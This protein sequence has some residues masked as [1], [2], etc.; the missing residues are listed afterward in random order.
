MLS[1]GK[2][3]AEQAGYYER[4]VA[5]GRDDY[6]SGK[7]EAP[8]AWAGR[9][10]AILGLQGVVDA[11][12]FNAM[13]AGL[14]PSDPDLERPL[15][16]ARGTPKVV[17]FDLTFSAPKSVSVEFATQDPQTSAQLIGAH[18][19][20]VA[21]ALE[22]VEDAAVRVRRGH[23]GAEVLAGDGVAAAAYR[24]RMSRSLDPQ[25]HTHVVC[26]NVTR[27]PD[28]RWTALD[29]RPIY[30]HARTAGF[31]YQAH[32]RAEVRDRLGWEW[33]PVVNGA[34]ELQHVKPELLTEFSR[35][36]HEI[37]A[38]ADVAI[39]RYETQHG[40]LSDDARAAMRTELLTAHG[41]STSR[42]P[43]ESASTSATRPRGATRCPHAPAS[44][45]MTGPPG[46]RALSAARSGYG[47]A[48]RRLRTS[49]S[50][51]SSAIGSRALRG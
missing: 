9:G 1:I 48:R 43:P 37:T 28:G 30:Q 46:K 42:W 19:S 6:Y 49:A 34:A 8:G 47:T 7:G 5:R 51:A 3:G 41:H 32:L 38:A 45:A 18:E 14:D 33:G 17:G 15:R 50:C 12:Q 26:A 23:A 11:A 13:I 20:A 27:G 25:L 39:A 44:T 4:Q 21:A 29:G 24:H 35:R 10:A 40:E 22:Y 2:L 31:L 16:D 36:R